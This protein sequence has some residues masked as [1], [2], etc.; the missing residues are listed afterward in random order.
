M[1]GRIHFIWALL[2]GLTL[3]PLLGYSQNNMAQKKKVLVLHSVEES[4]PWNTMFNNQLKESIKNSCPYDVELSMEYT[5]LILYHTEEYKDI[6]ERSIRY[7]YK[8]N[9]PDI[10]VITQIE[11]ANFVFER[12]LFPKTHKVL[13]DLSIDLITEHAHATNISVTLDFEAMVKHALNIFPQTKEV[14]VIAGNNNTDSHTLNLFINDMAVFKEDISFKYLN[15]LN[16]SA[17]LDSIKKLPENSLVYYLA[18]TQDLDGHAVMAKEFSI[19]IAQN[20]NR[21]VFSFLDLLTEE[22]GVFGGLVASL[23]SKA[24]KSVEVITQVFKGENME[25]IPPVEADYAYTYDWQELKK[26][27]IDIEQLPDS[28]IFYH[29]KYTFLELY[30]SEVIIG[31]FVLFS[32]TLLLIL[33]LYS[34]RKKRSS[35]KK[36]KVKNA[37]YELLNLEY[38]SQNEL[39]KV[40]KERAEESDRLKLAFL[41]NMSHEIRTPMNS[42]IGFSEMLNDEKLDI[43]QRKEFTRLINNG[44]IQLLNIIDDILEI[45]RLETHQVRIHPKLFSVNI[46]IK[47]LHA[48]FSLRIKEKGLSFTY[49]TALNDENCYITSDKAIINKILINLIENALK[50]THQGFIKLGYLT[51]PNQLIFFVKDSG[52]G[53]S[54]ENTNRIFDRFMQEEKALSQ[55]YGGLGLG[56]AISKENASLLSGDITV[57]SEKGKGSTFYLSIPY[58]SIK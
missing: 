26:W 22:T 51:M 32:Y 52:V 17:I 6:L 55:K 54:S 27:N 44:S 31:L 9:L 19:D 30:K 23:R 40:E 11:A 47:E 49:E 57:E 10:I 50:F 16:R 37:H 7:K 15:N 33:L 48:L 38:K 35:E 29:R 53:I 14:Y 56:L 42:I 58:P 34:N 3:F 46:L 21:P 12:N 43:A 25:T 4:R 13:I 28:S 20:C 45:S 1:K 39:L 2:S 41:L 24:I 5:D 36:L 8:N 18:Y